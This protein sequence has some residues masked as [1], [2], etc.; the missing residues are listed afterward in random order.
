MH[1]QLTEI[2]CFAHLKDGVGNPNVTKEKQRA[3]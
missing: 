3:T 2:N 1:I